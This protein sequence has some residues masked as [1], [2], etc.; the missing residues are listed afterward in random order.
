[1]EVSPGKWNII[2]DVRSFEESREK[3]PKDREEKVLFASWTVGTIPWKQDVEWHITDMKDLC[4][5][6]TVSKMENEG[7]E[8]DLLSLN[9][10]CVL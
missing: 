8:I 3:M 10:P 9:R 4:Y 2:R 7:G 1:M 6:I 5:R